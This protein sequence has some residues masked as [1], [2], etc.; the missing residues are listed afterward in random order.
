MDGSAVDATLT[1][2]SVELKTNP[3]PGGS[4]SNVFR[5]ARIDPRVIP[6]SMYA[7][8]SV[9]TASCLIGSADEAA[10][11]P[12]CKPKQGFRGTAL[13][14]LPPHPAMGTSSKAGRRSA[15]GG[16][17]GRLVPTEGPT[18]PLRQ[19]AVPGG[20]SRTCRRRGVTSYAHIVAC[21]RCDWPLP[22]PSRADDLGRTIQMSRYRLVILPVRL[23]ISSRPVM[24]VPR[25]S[26]TNTFH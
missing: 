23:R 21:T 6:H 19:Q 9:F 4:S 10:Q 3:Q 17:R 25:K 18:R 8:Y 24:L 7:N 15:S 2:Y 22:N 26:R 1:R 13:C 14:G 16:S 20:R 11:R 12:T 5:P